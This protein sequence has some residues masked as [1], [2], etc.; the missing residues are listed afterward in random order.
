MKGAPVLMTVL[1]VTALLAAPAA[2]GTQVSYAPVVASDVGAAELD[3]ATPS[4]G[5]AGWAGARAGATEEL[6]QAD[7][8]ERHGRGFDTPIGALSVL[9]IAAALVAAVAVFVVL[10]WPLSRSSTTSEDESDA[11]PRSPLVPN[12]PARAV[13]ASVTFVVVL[14]ILAE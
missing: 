5:S 1:V 2:G 14:L 12:L 8:D 3:G 4:M 7:D 6:A 10:S 11:R 9:R 13:A